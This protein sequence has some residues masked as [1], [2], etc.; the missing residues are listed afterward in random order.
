MRTTATYLYAITR[1]ISSAEVSELRGVGGTAVRVIA[2]REIA[3]LVS[4]V[5]LSDFAEQALAAHLED[6]DWL[7]R[8][9]REHDEVV[10]AAARIATTMPLRMATVCLDDDAVHTRLETLSHSAVAVLSELDGCDEWGVKM[11]AIGPPP[12]TEGTTAEPSTG[13][14]YL[15]QRRRQLA[16]RD[17]TRE[18]AAHDAGAAFARL[19]KVAVASRQHRPQDQRLSGAEHPMVLNAA[20]LV[21]R[22]D[23]DAFRAVMTDLVEQSP[24]DAFALTGPWPPYSFVPSEDL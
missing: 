22:Q 17:S 20:F 1:P 23:E 10:R 3:G 24:P 7:A 8:T 13:T 6:L 12:S 18:T 5:E 15:T 4:T 9:A 11:F 2:H 14:A 16:H 21:T 19:S